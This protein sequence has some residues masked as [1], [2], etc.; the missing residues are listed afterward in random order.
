MYTS[1]FLAENIF[2]LVATLG[3]IDVIFADAILPTMCI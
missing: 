1:L 3:Q 2:I